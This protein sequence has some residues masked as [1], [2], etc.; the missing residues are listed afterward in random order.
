MQQGIH[1]IIWNKFQLI[2]I[3]TGKS[4]NHEFKS[5]FDNNFDGARLNE[6]QWR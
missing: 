4:Y 1:S 2:Y 3:S 6:F 5:I